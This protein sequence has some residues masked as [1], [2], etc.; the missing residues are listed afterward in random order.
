M[1]EDKRATWERF[2]EVML[3]SGLFSQSVL[4]SIGIW[5]SLD[6]ATKL[7]VIE[8]EGGTPNIQRLAEDI[9]PLLSGHPTIDKDYKHVVD[10]DQ[11]ESDER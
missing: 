7:C 8:A 1:S 9:K 10:L 11:E 3:K 6:E 2:R 4:A 5:D